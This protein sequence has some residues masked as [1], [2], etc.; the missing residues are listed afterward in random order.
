[1]WIFES[2]VDPLCVNSTKVSEMF[3]EQRLNLFITTTMQAA[4]TRLAA[5]IFALRTE[6]LIVPC[7]AG[8]SVILG[9][10]SVCLSSDQ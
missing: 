3:D 7:T 9:C 4:A 1:M 10:C 6:L 8:Q 5:E 2:D